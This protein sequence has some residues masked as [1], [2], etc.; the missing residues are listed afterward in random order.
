[1]GTSLTAGDVRGEQ[2]MFPKRP[3]DRLTFISSRVWRSGERVNQIKA[4]SLISRASLH[5]QRVI[6]S[7]RPGAQGSDPTLVAGSPPGSKVELFVGLLKSGRSSHNFQSM[8]Q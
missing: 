3:K 4:A 8:K 5:L 1:M 6:L 2:F 7:L